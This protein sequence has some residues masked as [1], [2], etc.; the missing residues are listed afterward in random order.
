LIFQ[1]FKCCFSPPVQRPLIAP[2]SRLNFRQMKIQVKQSHY[3]LLVRLCVN[4]S[5]HGKPTPTGL[6]RLE[7]RPDLAG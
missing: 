5:E 6:K 7:R 3:L 4:L 2:S 1:V